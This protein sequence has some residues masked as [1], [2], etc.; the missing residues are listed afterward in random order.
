MDFS[1]QKVEIQQRATST[2]L[3]PWQKPS[4]WEM[5][6]IGQVGLTGIRKPCPPAAIPKPSH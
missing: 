2:I 5:L 4:C 3:G 1:L 6:P